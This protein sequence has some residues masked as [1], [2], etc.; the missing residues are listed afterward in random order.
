MAERA[1][2]LNQVGNGEAS[3]IDQQAHEVGRLGTLDRVRK[4]LRPNVQL[5]KD[6]AL[7]RSHRFDAFAATCRVS[8]AS[9]CICSAV[10]AT[11][12][13]SAMS[14]AALYVLHSA[15]QFF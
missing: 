8:L 4:Q 14:R 12:S 2:G 11:S 13:T 6:A 1:D 3:W 7:G 9:R 10:Y 5:R 15:D